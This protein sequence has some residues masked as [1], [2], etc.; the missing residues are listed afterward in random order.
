MG[1]VVRNVTVG[2]LAGCSGFEGEV[3]IGVEER[4]SVSEAVAVPAPDF[5]L[6][7]M[8]L[9]FAP[10]ELKKRLNMRF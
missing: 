3:N 8:G 10:F 4:G 6:G 7:K 1:P 9:M 2:V 5:V